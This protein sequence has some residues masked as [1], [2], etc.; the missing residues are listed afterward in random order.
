M[1]SAVGRLQTF[2]A[3]VVW[4][5]SH[6][7]EID[8]DDV[9]VQLA[10]EF[11]LPTFPQF[12]DLV[13]VCQE[14]GVAVERFRVATP[15]LDGAHTWHAEGAPVIYLSPDLPLVRQES[16]LLH[17]LREV[18]EE[19]FKAANP[20]Y[21]G[22]DPR[23]NARMNPVSD[24][25]AAAVLMPKDVVRDE[26]Q[27]LGFDLPF[28]ARRYNRSLSSVLVRFDELFRGRPALRMGDG[29]RPAG[30]DCG[31]AG[32]IRALA[33]LR[34]TTECRRP[35]LR[36]PARRSVGGTEAASADY[37]EGTRGL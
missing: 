35:W 25:F 5:K 6:Y 26:L 7:A 27:A 4:G 28:F 16:T 37:M 20:A 31:S 29:V 3:A 33:R 12:A 1:V 13:R 24:R 19:A 36:P 17:E 34:S 10:A 30:V 21:V 15:G 2:A 14:L 9:A 18:L 32:R 22:L 8:P 11:Q 23:H